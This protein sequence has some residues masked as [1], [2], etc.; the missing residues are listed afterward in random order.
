M[1]MGKGGPCARPRVPV[2]VALRLAVA[3]AHRVGTAPAVAASRARAVQ[4]DLCGER[5]QNSFI[6]VDEA[7][8]AVGVGS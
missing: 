6:A 1:D 4:C 5:P 7:W 3:E 2:S 8:T